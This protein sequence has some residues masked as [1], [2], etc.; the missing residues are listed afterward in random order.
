MMD[1]E[2]FIESI[3]HT[4]KRASWIAPVPFMRAT[5]EDLFEALHLCYAKKSSFDEDDY[6]WHVMDC[7]AKGMEDTP[8]YRAD[9]LLVD[10]KTYEGKEL[11]GYGLEAIY[12]LDEIDDAEAC[13]A[14]L[15]RKKLRDRSHY[16]ISIRSD[17]KGRYM[18]DL[19]ESRRIYSLELPCLLV[20]GVRV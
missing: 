20:R 4:A 13:R 16:G 10:I 14:W 19:A 12:V 7:M 17:E 1:H 3:V 9:A 6:E 15:D 11:V 5:A 2:F 8:F 18:R